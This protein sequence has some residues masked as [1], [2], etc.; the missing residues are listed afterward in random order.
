MHW[1][2]THW[3]TSDRRSL[4][5]HLFH[6]L[7]ALFYVVPVGHL[8]WCWQNCHGAKWFKQLT[9][10]ERERER[11]R[12]SGEARDRVRYKLFTMLESLCSKR[13]FRK[14][15]HTHTHTHISFDP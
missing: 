8:N 6:M 12:E 10:R 5:A 7:M 3:H 9:Q 14:I 4:A 11:E 2:V 15:A 13:T 1:R